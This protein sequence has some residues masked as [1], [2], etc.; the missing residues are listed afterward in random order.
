MRQ[1]LRLRVLVPVAV[2]GLLGAGFGAFAMG[3]PEAPVSIPVQRAT[4][5]GAVDTGATDTGAVDTGATDTGPAPAPP[6]PPQ[7]TAGEVE[8]AAWAEQAN[9][10]C[11]QLDEQVQALG[12]FQSP[13]EAKKWFVQALDLLHAF[14]DDFAALGWPPGEK[15]AVT[16]I[17]ATIASGVGTVEELQAA[18]EAEDV[19]ELIRLTKEQPGEKEEAQAANAELRRLGA[20]ECAK[21]SPAS[22]AEMRGSAALQW[23][24][25]KY[26]AVVVVFASP[27]SVVDNGAVFEARAAALATNAGF[28]AVD[29]TNEKQVA[30]IAIGYEVL[31]SP[32]VLVITRGPKLRSEL[33]GFVDQETI[34]QAVTNAL[35]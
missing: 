24:L 13:N 15:G 4:S 17:N 26:R 2:L 16:G 21:S 31:E 10:L 11:L 19:D 34:A 9:A 28:V 27:D 12:E 5:S 14:E 22:T 33:R 20:T 7:P 1:Q 32:T 6:P 30:A 3:G 29:V 25:L 18:L 23:Q 35:K 8:A